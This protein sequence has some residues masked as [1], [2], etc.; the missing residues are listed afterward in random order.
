MTQTSLP[1][2]VIRPLGIRDAQLIITAFAQ[3][4]P[5]SRYR[6]FGRTLIEPGQVVGWTRELDGRHR[7]AIGAC[8]RASGA[9]I[10][11]A[12]YVSLDGKSAEIA[13]TVL[14][15]WQGM[16]AGRTLLDNL[17]AHARRSGLR[18]LRAMVVTDNYP[19]VRLLRSIG[20]ERIESHAGS[21]KEY[22]APLPA[23]RAWEPGV[24][25]AP[26]IGVGD[27]R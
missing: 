10:G 6:R 17:L 2:L 16:G 3:L 20:A 21:M 7:V 14:D 1:S 24:C 22:V 23:L 26:T 18:E 9:P 19:A 4:S 11:V 5:E 15:P 12:R 13:V 8:A 27:K 25:G